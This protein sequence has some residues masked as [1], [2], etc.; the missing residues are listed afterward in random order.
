MAD[1]PLT[2]AVS[3]LKGPTSS[4][5]LAST[6]TLQSHSTNVTLHSPPSPQF[7]LVGKQSWFLAL[8]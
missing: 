5:L 4:P 6:P 3:I 8:K 1:P 2:I 7:H